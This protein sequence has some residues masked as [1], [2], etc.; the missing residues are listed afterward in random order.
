MHEEDMLMQRNGNEQCAINQNTNIRAPENSSEETQSSNFSFGIK[1]NL[2]SITL[3]SISRI[4]AVSKQVSQQGH[5]DIAGK[6]EQI[7]NTNQQGETSRM[8][9]GNNRVL[10]EYQNNFPKISNN[11]ARYD[12]NTL[13]NQKGENHVNNNVPQN[14]RKQPHS[15]QQGQV[16][17]QETIPEPAPFTIVQSC[18][19]RL[20]YNQ[21]KNEIPI[22]LDSPLH[23][24]R[25]GLR[26]VLLD[27]NDY[28][29]KL[30]E[31]C[32]HT[33]VGKF[34]NTMPKME[35]IRKSFTLQTQLTG[36]VNNKN[37]L[38][39]YT[40]SRKKTWVIRKNTA[41]Q[42][43]ASR[44]RSKPIP[45]PCG[46][47]C[48]PN[49]KALKRASNW[50]QHMQEDQKEDREG[51]FNTGGTPPQETQNRQEKKQDKIDQAK[52]KGCKDNIKHSGIDSMLPTPVNPTIVSMVVT[53]SDE[54]EGG[55]NGGCQENHIN[56]QEGTDMDL[57]PKY[58]TTATTETPQHK[59]RKTPTQHYDKTGMQKQTG[60]DNSNNKQDAEQNAEDNQ[61][62]GAMA[63]DMGSKAGTSQQDITPK[64]K[65]KPSKK[66]REAA[67]KR[68]NL[69]QV[70][71]KEE[72][73]KHN[74]E[75]YTGQGTCHM[76][77]IPIIDEYAVEN[78]EDDMDEDNQSLKGP[79]DEE[80]T[81]ELL[82]KAFTS[83]YDH[84]FEQE[85]QQVANKQG[86]SPRGFQHEKFHFKSRIKEHIAAV[87]HIQ[88][89]LPQNHPND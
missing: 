28:N 64:S 57:D 42:K 68:Q 71:E 11:Y 25:Q 75:A 54:A 51:P 56:L 67:K 63:K 34:T 76:N 10:T 3:I 55:M 4:T 89:C 32:N 1:D 48:H 50:S 15:Q 43:E 84:N 85:I 73:Q 7:T 59:A 14:N 61:Q 86:L 82:I 17:K 83:N 9:Q 58:R 31:S 65:N 41:I 30:V 69:Q 35:I 87:H 60:K 62:R 40:I 5:K 12:S 88:D 18:A 74:E 49:T 47:L 23:T 39:T 22:V 70:K 80:D 46:D 36:G 66:K 33:L 26:V 2:V 78:S 21:S 38:H 37:Q 27:E 8:Q 13:R 16:Q 45:R 79:E 52:H 44:T 6:N 19:A 77:S 53:C 81:S 20:R 24:T 29:V 72:Q